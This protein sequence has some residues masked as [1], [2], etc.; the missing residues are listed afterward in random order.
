MPFARLKGARQG[1]QRPLS[2]AHVTLLLGGGEDGRVLVVNGQC[3]WVLVDG[4]RVGSKRGRLLA[5]VSF[6]AAC[7]GALSLEKLGSEA[8]RLCCSSLCQ[9]RRDH[10]ATHSKSR[11]EKEG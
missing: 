11:M 4:I 10:P 1:L 9:Q 7:S 3:Y 5:S 8:Q 6:P 2:G